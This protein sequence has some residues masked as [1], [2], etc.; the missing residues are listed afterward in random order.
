MYLI[1]ILTGSPAVRIQVFLSRRKTSSLLRCANANS[2]LVLI[3]SPFMNIFPI[4]STSY[5][6]CSWN[7]ARVMGGACS[8]HGRDEYFGW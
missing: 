3:H 2:F 7:S 4:H 5:N 6:T 1:R 8:T